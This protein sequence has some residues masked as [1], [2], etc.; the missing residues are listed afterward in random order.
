M[1]DDGISVVVGGMCLRSVCVCVEEERGRKEK[2][3]ATK[4]DKKAVF[5]CVSM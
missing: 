2:D 5:C 1:I 3:G 4:V